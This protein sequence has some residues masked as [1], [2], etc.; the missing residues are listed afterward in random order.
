MKYQLEIAPN[1]SIFADDKN[2]FAIKMKDWSVSF[3]DRGDVSAL[4]SR[5]FQQYYIYKD[6][7]SPELKTRLG[8]LKLSLERVFEQLLEE[9]VKK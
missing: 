3:I 2:A 1:D 6:K 9:D 7:V 5:I 4:Y 8:G